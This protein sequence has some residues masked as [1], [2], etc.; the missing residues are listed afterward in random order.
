[1]I[2]YTLVYDLDLDVIKHVETNNLVFTPSFFV[3]W[4]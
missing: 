1:M 4:M 2:K 3:Y